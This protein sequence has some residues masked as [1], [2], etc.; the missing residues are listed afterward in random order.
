LLPCNKQP[1]THSLRLAS[2]WTR[3]GESDLSEHSVWYG[4]SSMGELR[5][6]ALVAAEAAEQQCA[7]LVAARQCFVPRSTKV[8]AE[9]LKS[10]RY[11]GSRRCFAPDHQGLLADHSRDV[12][13]I[14]HFDLGSCPL[15]GRRCAGAQ[16]CFAPRDPGPNAVSDLNFSFLGAQV[17]TRAASESDQHARFALR[18]GKEQVKR[19][20][21]TQK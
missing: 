9:H 15:L 19:E 13:G 12:V 11:A 10:Y 2:L 20:A 17:E 3:A 14:E 16:G 18:K 4:I 8:P 21:P 1:S 7:G 6:R 5:A